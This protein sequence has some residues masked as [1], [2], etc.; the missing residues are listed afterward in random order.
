[1][2]TTGPGSLAPDGQPYGL[3][4]PVITIRDMVRAHVLLLTPGVERLYG[5]IGGS[6]GG[7]QALSLAVNWPERG[8]RAG[9]GQHGGDAGAEHRLS[10]AGPSGDHGRSRLAGRRLLRH[11]PAPMRV[12]P[13]RGWPRISP[14]CPKRRCRRNSGGGCRTVRP[15]F[16]F[17]ADFQVESYLRY[18]GESFTGRFDANSTSTS[19]RR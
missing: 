17:G 19:P 7:M 5:V 2:G 9:A 16:G 18:Q 4:F 11:R 10:G 15:S 14:I 8:A 12:W 13:W 3:R 1:M 6:M